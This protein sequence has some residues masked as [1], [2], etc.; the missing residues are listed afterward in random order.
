MTIYLG[1]QMSNQESCQILGGA[2]GMPQVWRSQPH[3]HKYIGGSF[4]H[5]EPLSKGVWGMVAYKA[6]MALSH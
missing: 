4:S 5:L 2:N 6:K 1:I 3:I